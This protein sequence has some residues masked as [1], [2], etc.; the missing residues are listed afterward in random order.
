MTYTKTK[1]TT[2]IIAHRGASGLTGEDNTLKSFR[3]AWLMSCDMVEFDVRQ[4]KCGA[5][6]CFHDQNLNGALI[7][8]LTLSELK[9]L[10]ACDI[11]LL[12][13]TVIE[14]KGKI[15][16][17]VEIKEHGFEKEIVEIL[18]KHLDKDAYIVKSF[19]PEVVKKIAEIDASVRRGLLLS[20]YDKDDKEKF[21]TESSKA[22]KICQPH[23]LGVYYK[24]LE[25]WFLEHASFQ[26]PI[27]A[28]TV[29]NP[30][31]MQNI[32]DLN[33]EGIITDRPDY[34]IEIMSN[35]K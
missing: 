26:F 15:E 11:P 23:F 6:I 10:V 31:D 18:Q 34:L 12:E 7:S 27:L 13:E 16:L 19:M 5:I 32:L 3:Q 25:P 28:W 1:E 30:V 9:S 24:V 20:G 4:T 33:I 29:N 35:Y 21:I 22:I 8:D 2:K 17:D 14:C